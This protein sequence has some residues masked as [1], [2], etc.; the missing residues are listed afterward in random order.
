MRWRLVLAFLGVVTVM[1][2]AQDIPL[3]GHL[4]DVERDR[5]LTDLERDAFIVAGQAATALR[6]DIDTES[7]EWQREALAD[8]VTSNADD[9]R[10]II[11]VDA[12]GLVVTSAGAS[13]PS[14][15]TDLSGE[16]DIV[17]ALDRRSAAGDGEGFVSVAV[18]VLDGADAVGAVRVS[19]PGSVIDDR[20]NRRVR[21]LLVVAAISL[22]VAV[23]VASLVS[24]TVT[25]PLRRLQRSTERV[26]TGDFAARVEEDEGP[27]EVRRLARS[28]NTMTARIARSVAQQQAFAGDASHQLRTPLTALR[29]QLERTIALVESEPRGALRNLEAA[30]GEISRLQRMIDGLLLLSRSDELRP[31]D[32]V[33]VRADEVVAERVAVWTPLAEELGVTITTWS[34]EPVTVMALPGALDQIIDNYLD[35]AIAVAPTDTS[36]EVVV[37]AGEAGPNTLATIHVLDRGPGLTDAQLAAAFGRFWRAPDN[38]Q[39]GTGLGL[40]IVAHLAASSGGEAS[41]QR[42]PG[43]GVDASVELKRVRAQ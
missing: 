41:L 24:S 34:A 33:P 19:S 8:S 13:Q 7:R 15:G 3:V 35:N 26:A 14:I 22:G 28:F 23:V 37:D 1:L 10:A 2:L 20:A 36:V 42:R 29:L 21:G 6:G 16:P 18:P 38:D 5:Q 40:A 32:L 27:P 39:E 4:R 25:R 12:D 43:G 17:A 31:A 30:A 11:V 9:D